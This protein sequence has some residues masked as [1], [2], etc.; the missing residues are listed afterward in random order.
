MEDKICASY[1]DQSWSGT[2]G[3]GNK[4]GLGGFMVYKLLRLIVVEP[5]ASKG[6]IWEKEY[7][8]LLDDMPADGFIWRPY[9]GITIPADRVKRQFG[10]AQTIPHIMA[11][12][13]SHCRKLSKHQD[14]DWRD[15]NKHWV[16][17][18]DLKRF[19]FIVEEEIIDLSSS[20]K[21][22]HGIK[23]LPVIG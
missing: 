16:H 20:A 14:H 6:W 8:A 9:K 10:I 23:D 22:W 18:W 21:Y 13:E 1:G 7:R 17:M 3:F 11:V 5:L 15:I 2:V 4:L 12:G 19:N